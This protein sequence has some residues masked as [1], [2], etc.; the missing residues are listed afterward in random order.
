MKRRVIQVAVLLLLGAIG[1]VAVAL[2]SFVSESTSSWTRVYTGDVAV[3]TR[4]GVTRVERFFGGKS[5]GT[6]GTI[7]LA[8]DEV[9]SYAGI[10]MRSIQ[11]PPTRSEMQSILAHLQCGPGLWSTHS[12]T[13]LFCGWCLSV[14]PTSAGICESSAGFVRRV[15]IRSAPQQ[16]APNA[17]RSA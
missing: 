12:S 10:P 3:S 8:G 16:S 11:L 17:A 14:L 13:R 1:N 6:T 7:V 5:T 9:C 15:R 4:F 2:G